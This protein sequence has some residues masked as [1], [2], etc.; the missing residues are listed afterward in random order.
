MNLIINILIIMTGLICAFGEPIEP[1][2]KATLRGLYKK[3]QDE[4]IHNDFLHH[5]NEIISGAKLG[6]N[7]YEFTPLCYEVIQQKCKNGSE[8]HKLWIQENGSLY[9]YGITQEIYESEILN[10]LRETFIDSN[11]NKEFNNCCN[12]YTI[13]W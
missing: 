11:I 9:R 12:K 3:Q 5:Y 2:Y 10:K 13:E 4:L 7:K 6:V 1:M 8:G